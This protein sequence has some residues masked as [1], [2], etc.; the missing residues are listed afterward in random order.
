MDE[1][2]NILERDSSAEP[3]CFVGFSLTRDDEAIFLC[4]CG[5]T[6][7]GEKEFQDHLDKSVS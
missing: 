6:F 3:H 1:M 7:L 2:M 4:F 5:E